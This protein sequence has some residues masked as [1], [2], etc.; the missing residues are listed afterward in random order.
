MK[1]VDFSVGGGSGLVD[2]LQSELEDNC[3]RE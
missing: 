1:F 2:Q 3:L